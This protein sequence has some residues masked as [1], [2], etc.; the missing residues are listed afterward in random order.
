MAWEVG[1]TWQPEV[2]VTDDGE[3]AAPATILLQVRSPAGVL[4]TVATT[5]PALGVYRGNVVLTAAGPWV[6]IFTTTSPAQVESI[7]IFADPAPATTVM[8]ATIDELARRLGMVDAG[9]LSAGQV[10]QGTML[11]RLM[12]SVIAQEVGRTEAWVATVNP[13][14]AILRAVCLEA[15]ARVMQNPSGARSESET[16]GQWSHS[17]NYTDKAHGL[18]LTAAESRLVCQEV[19]GTASATTHPATTLDELIELSETG[20][21]AP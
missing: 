3:P 13:I 14:P 4:A 1:D 16:L 11:L 7:Q 12:T 18:L 20:Q 10:A 2:T 21:I 17:T 8:F 15:V 5:N 6:A 19:W 9:E